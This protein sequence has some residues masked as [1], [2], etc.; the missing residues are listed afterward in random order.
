[1]VFST[2]WNFNTSNTDDTNIII[3]ETVY[4]PNG[5]VDNYT[6][7]EYNDDQTSRV[8]TTLYYG[9]SNVHAICI[10]DDQI[11]TMKSVKC[12]LL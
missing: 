1:M 10:Y 11:R 2:E 8:K 7:Y 4:Y 12:V 6:I 5:E 9:N 3:K